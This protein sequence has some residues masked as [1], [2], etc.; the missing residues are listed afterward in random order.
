MFRRIVP[1]KIDTKFIV[2]NNIATQ[3]NAFTATDLVK[4]LGITDNDG[5]VKEEV[6][7]KLR[8]VGEEREKYIRGLVE[9]SYKDLFSKVHV[10][11]AKKD[12]VV[13][14]FV[15]NHKFGTAQAKYAA[16]LFLHLCHKYNIVVSEELKKK[17]HTG[18]SE[19]KNREKKNSLKKSKKEEGNQENNSNKDIG[20]NKYIVSIYG[21][22]TSFKFPINNVSDFEDMEA[23][24]KIIKKKLS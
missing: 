19:I 24:L 8:L 20:D 10:S 21:E 9:S 11:E 2:E 3:N 4:W 6:M 12:D 22:N 7:S 5:N 15:H 23:I 16:A 1:K 14:Y 17:T 13:N 18:S